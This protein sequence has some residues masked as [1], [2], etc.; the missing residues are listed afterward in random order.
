MMVHMLRDISQKCLVFVLYTACFNSSQIIIS[1]ESV[2]T[3][4]AIMLLAANMGAS[5]LTA[6]VICFRLDRMLVG[7]SVSSKMVRITLAPATLMVVT[8]SCNGWTS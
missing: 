5:V 1:H 8:L 4:P 3:E 7:Q 6:N 2:I